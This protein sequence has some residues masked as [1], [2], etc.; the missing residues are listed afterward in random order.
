MERHVPIRVIGKVVDKDLL[1]AINGE[2]LLHF[3]LE[4]LS[5]AYYHALE[6]S[7]HLDEL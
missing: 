4:E 1:I 5:G 7:L 2:G 6:H 3:T